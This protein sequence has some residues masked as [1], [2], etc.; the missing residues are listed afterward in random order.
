MMER[1][2]QWIKRS[3]RVGGAM[4]EAPH[5]MMRKMIAMTMMMMPVLCP[6]RSLTNAVWKYNREVALTDTVLLR[7]TQSS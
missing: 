2:E 7:V 6:A 4:A 5:M 3:W 1:E